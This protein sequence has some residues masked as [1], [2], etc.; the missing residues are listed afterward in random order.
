MV[1]GKWTIV[2]RWTALGLLG[3]VLFGLSTSSTQ[4]VQLVNAFP[5]L[6]FHQPVFITH[7]NDGTDRLF[8]VQQDGFI[9]VFAND[10]N[11][12]TSTTFLNVSAKLSAPNG[13]EGLLGLAFDPHFAQN[14]YFYIDYTAPSPLHSVVARY[15]VL[16]GNPNKADSLN[17]FILLTVNQPFTNHKAGALAFGPDS[18]LYIAL[19]DGGS[20]G[21]PMNNGQNCTQ[22]L[23]KILRIDVRDT[24]ASTHYRI[25]SD[26]PF[27]DDMTGKRG[28]IWAFGLRNPWRFSF[29]SLTGCFGPA[30]LGRTRA[31]KSTS[32]PKGR[33]TGG[34]SWKGR[35]VTIP[36]PDAIPPGSRC[37]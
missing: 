26:N 6:T 21:D 13:E 17:E 22:L 11:A 16:P 20:G 25:P 32:S 14:G 3:A 27:A 1:D 36:L 29:D 7:S 10:S 2:N 8:V 18:D 23:G 34:E 33:T 31:K 28:E 15:R 4:T 19:G 37:R 35:P 5:H 12:T 24:T 30:M 9:K